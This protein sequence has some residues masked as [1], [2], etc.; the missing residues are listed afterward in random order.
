MENNRG[1]LPGN[2]V[3][4]I[5]VGRVHRRA[6]EKTSDGARSI[7]TVICNTAPNRGRSDIA[8]VV[9]GNECLH[10]Q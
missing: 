2:A 4:P 5:I 6:S 8:G 9:V 3:L 1:S 10:T 7:G